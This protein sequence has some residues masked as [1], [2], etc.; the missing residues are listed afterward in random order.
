VKRKPKVTEVTHG[1]TTVR[2]Y[3]TRSGKYTRFE[4]LYHL[5]DVFKRERI[6][7]KTKAFRRADSLAKSL[8]KG[9][10]VN[11][12]LT[13]ADAAT[14]AHCKAV[15]SAAGHT[16]EY[17]VSYAVESLKRHAITSKAIPD[18]V[19][20]ML[21]VKEGQG[22]SASHVRDLEQRLGRFSESF[23]GQIADLTGKLISDW[24]LA[25]TE[26]KD[27]SHKLSKRS[28]NNYRRTIL[29]LVEY[30][31]Q[32]RY[33]PKD[34]SEL[35]AVAIAKVKAGKINPYSPEELEAILRAAENHRRPSIR[36][37]LPWITVRAFSG[38][39]EA[40]ICRLTDAD[41]VTESECITLG[42]DITKTGQRRV[43]PLKTNLMLWLESIGVISEKSWS[44]DDDGKRSPPKLVV[45]I[46][47][48]TTR[49]NFLLSEIGAVKR[50]NGLRD[51]YASYRMAETTDAA[52]VAE[53]CGH[54]IE[55]LRTSYREIRLEDGRVITKELA[56]KWFSILP[57]KL[58]QKGD[59]HKT[60]VNIS[61]NGGSGG[62]RIHPPE[63]GY[64]VT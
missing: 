48:P 46:P 17:L 14:Y 53:E 23:P 64:V 4:I 55:R 47:N 52:K 2:V 37:M 28:R 20:E 36:E 44:I 3:E 13:P 43:I 29:S 56:E 12:S 59:H 42:S 24:L 5:G 51:S 63:T 41:I 7:D 57:Q 62:A 27:E 15:A 54:S 19:D 50:H 9:E 33:L 11:A 38:M 34:W 60:P 6:S 35:D 22:L 8:S 18:I 45:D 10:H 40:E 21:K 16:L 32:N 1:S 31:K 26:V 25:L 61:G 39:R 58:P 49:W 30:A